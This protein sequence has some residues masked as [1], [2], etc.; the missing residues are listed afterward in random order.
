LAECDTDFHAELLDVADDIQDRLKL[1][2][3]FF[4]PFPSGPHAETACTSGLG[5]TRFR[6]DVLTLHQS[7]GLDSSVVASALGAVPAIF[8]ATASFDAEQAAELNSFFFAPVL[9]MD[10]AGLVEKGK[11][12][13]MVN[14][15][16]LGKCFESHSV[17]GNHGK[18]VAKKDGKVKNVCSGGQEEE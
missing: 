10:P 9:A 12:R 15:R 8:T 14:G 16:E 3:P 17:D 11:Q 2:F 13:L 6:K 4:D 7:L 5:L 18:R 1:G